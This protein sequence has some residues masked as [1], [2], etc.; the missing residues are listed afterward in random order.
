M[1]INTASAGTLESGDIFIEIM[2]AKPEQK[3][4]EIILS[5]TVSHQFGEQI[6]KVITQTLSELNI[7]DAIVNATDKG[8]LDCTVKARTQA[9]VCRA[10]KTDLWQ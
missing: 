7:T 9:A 6:K 2:P 3:G 8:A 4:I 1:K 10:T 5:S